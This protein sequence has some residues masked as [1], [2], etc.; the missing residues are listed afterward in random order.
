[1]LKNENMFWFWKSEIPAIVCDNIVSRGLEL[2]EEQASVG[3]GEN[4]IV[5]ENVRKSRISWFDTGK[6]AWLYHVLW[7]YMVR[8]NT[9]AGWNFDIK[10][11]QQPQFTVYD[12]SFFYDFHE[13]AS[14]HE[15]NMRKLS[16]VVFLSETTDYDGGNFEFREPAEVPAEKGSILV[17]PSF[18]YHRVTPV[19]SGLRY[20]LVNWFTGPSL[21]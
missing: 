21:V 14:Y 1:M 18:L 19:E 11:Q 3:E 10:E 7:G 12:K 6:D 15:D 5:D 17:F 16:L 9:N 4:G 2:T 13:D 20:S 8:A